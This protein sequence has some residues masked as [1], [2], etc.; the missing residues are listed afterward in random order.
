MI[1]REELE[2]LHE[3]ATKGDL[4]TA[5]RHTESEW[6]ECPFCQGQGEVEAADY[7][8]FDGVAL[9]VQFYGIGK[10]FGAHEAL[11]C[12]LRNAVPDILNLLTERDTLSAENARLEEANRTVAAE[13]IKWAREAGEAK[14]KLE[15]S[16]AAGVVDQWREKCE[17]LE[18]EN[19]ALTAKVERM[20]EALTAMDRIVESSIKENDG[21]YRAHWKGEVIEGVA[22]EMVYSVLRAAQ[23]LCRATLKG[24]EG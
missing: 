5:E 24:E 4:T 2:R 16:E 3:A 20:E 11:W 8:N 19:A 18:A 15:G 9:G 17:Q 6:V 23:R 1:D 10:E 14:G 12:Y 13:C 21:P 7:C 22:A